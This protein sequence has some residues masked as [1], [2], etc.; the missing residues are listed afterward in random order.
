MTYS[1]IAQPALVEVPA[2]RDLIAAWKLFGTIARYS[3]ARPL[4]E[5]QRRRLPRELRSRLQ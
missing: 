2:H 5:A 4:T 1:R 3:C